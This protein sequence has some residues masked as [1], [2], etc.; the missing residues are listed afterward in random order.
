M[1]EQIYDGWGNAYP[2]KVNPDGSINTSNVSPNVNDSRT[3]I[4]Y[5]GNAIGS[6]W[7]FIGTGSYVRV[8]AYN[9]SGNIISLS[10]WTAV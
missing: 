5:S 2:L 6:I 3:V 10:A 1:A 8:A 9:G 7:E 4:Q